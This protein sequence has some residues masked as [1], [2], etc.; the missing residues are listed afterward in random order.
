[1]SPRW[2][3]LGFAI[4]VALLALPCASGARTRADDDQAQLLTLYQPVL[5]FHASED[6][7]P[8]AV[9]RYLER[10][11]VERQVA[12]GTWLRVPPPLPTSYAGCTLSPCLRLDL[13]CALRA[14]Y[15]CYHRQA[16]A[17]TDW[18]APVMY[19]SVAPVPASTPP[20]P[21]QTQRPSL[22]LHYWLFYAVDD[23]HSLRDRLWQTHEGDWES[24]TIGLDAAH[25]PLFAAYSEHCSGTIFPWR[26]VA[27]RGATHP[28]AY[29]ALGSHANWFTS[30]AANTHFADC[31]KS[32]LGASAK[33]R[34]TT[35]FRLAEDKVVDRMGTSHPSG[36]AG[37]PGVT[38]MMLITIG[39]GVTPWVTFPGKWGEG[40][41][42]WLGKTPHPA[43]TISRGAAPGTP[44]W[45]A[46]QIGA[47]WHP[48]T[49]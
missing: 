32:G 4:V 31:L 36:P 25:T 26:A 2:R 34:L 35:L 46:P 30:S 3:S 9:D 23:W 43:T 8:Q 19:G 42:V 13:P 6:W 39:T 7:A 41:I 11:R 37:L 24:I 47:V 5:F 12:K 14:G 48:L 38:P 21:G 28:V 49:G 33:A 1:V 45:F 16:L 18:K 22:L 17:E 44:K 15:I 40:Q 29:V 27:K 20:P 10:V